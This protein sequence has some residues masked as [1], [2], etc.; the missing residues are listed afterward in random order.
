[1]K[2]SEQWLRQWVNPKLTTHELTEQITML[3]L[4]VEAVI[5]V[6]KKFSTVVIGEVITRTQH[7]NADKLSCCEVNVGGTQPL[8]IVCG[9]SN[10][11]AGIKV[12]VALVGAVLRAI[13]G[14]V[15]SRARDG[16]EG[17]VAEIGGGS[18]R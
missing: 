4:T 11:R 15:L 6:A 1:M 9:A 7:P 2:L 12:A 16:R 10:V 17:D 5:A 3:G 13:G 18:D 14:D 8:K